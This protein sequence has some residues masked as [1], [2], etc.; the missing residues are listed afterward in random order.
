MA[1]ITEKLSEFAAQLNYDDLPA[2]VTHHAKRIILD[3]LGC[4][5]G[6]YHSEPSRIVR[7]MLQKIGGTPECTIIGT[8]N[9][10]SSPN[11]ALVNGVMTRYLDYNDTYIGRDYAHPSENLATALAVGERGHASGK[12]VI[13]AF[14]LGC[15]FHQ[16]FVDLIDFNANE[17]GWSHVSPGGYVTALVAAKLLKL[18]PAL[19]TNAIGIGGSHNHALR[20]MYGQEGGHI[21]MMKTIGW[22]FA[23]QSGIMA[24]LLAQDGFTGP[25][26]IIESLCRVVGGNI[27]PIRLLPKRGEFMILQ[28][29]LKPSPSYYMSHS[30]ITATLDLRKEHGINAEDVAEINVRIFDRV[31]RGGMRY[32]PE[33]RE[34]ADHSIP[35]L[36][37][38]ALT[39]GDVGPEQFAKERWKDPKVRA[40]IEKV[41]LASDPELDKLFPVRRPAIVEI[42]TKQGATYTKR[43]DCPRGTPENPMTDE[44]IEAK[45]RGMAVPLMREKQ[46]QSI[47]EACYGLEQMTDIGLLMPLLVF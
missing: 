13:T 8:G 3:T 31:F 27:D 47:F 1:T 10:T 30:P 41:K 28:S 17:Q 21:T 32:V 11:A 20:G 26:A 23:A 12:D 36:L 24:A 9:K 6:A 35:F 18:S 22:H 5:F 39:D 19:M 2:A 45:F 14:V 43:V 34:T 38:V 44:E 25:A 42:R 46:M 37:A 29:C 40:L 4:A 7:G 33:T 16:R 15:E